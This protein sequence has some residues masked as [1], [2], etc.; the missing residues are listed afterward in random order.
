MAVE[1]KVIYTDQGR[2]K[3]LDLL[4]CAPP[5]PLS[6]RENTMRLPSL[7]ACSSD[8]SLKGCLTDR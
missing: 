5:H 6:D 8:N 3:F 7:A 4:R 1:V 2:Q